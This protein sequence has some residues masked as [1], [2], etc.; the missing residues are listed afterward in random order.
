MADVTVV[1][2]VAETELPAAAI[3]TDQQYTA[4]Y[5]LLSDSC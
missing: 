2:D 1:D 5:C 4:Y 3:Q